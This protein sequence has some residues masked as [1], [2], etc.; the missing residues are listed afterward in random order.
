MPTLNNYERFRLFLLSINYISA[1]KTPS[2]SAMRKI[3]CKLP[4][5]DFINLI[6]SIY[7]YILHDPKEVIKDICSLVTSKIGNLYW[8][9]VTIDQ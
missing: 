9:R 1:H 3:F 8:Y 5:L 2:I 7:L 6:I 4:I